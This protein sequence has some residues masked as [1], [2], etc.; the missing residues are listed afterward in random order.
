MQIPP[1]TASNPLTAATAASTGP[2]TGLPQQSLGENDFLKLLAAQLAA[3]DP[4]QPTDNTQFIAQMASFSSLQQM[5]SL[6]Q[7]FTQF[8]AT[9]NV[10]N[11]SQYLG[12]QVTVADAKGNPVSGVA[13]G[14]QVANGSVTLTVNGQPYPVTS[15][16]AVSITSP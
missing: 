11:A 13:T 9:Q 2:A 16:T 6:N 5:S 10:G 3:Q 7:N 12:K 14:Y 8:A 4:L 1:L 15:V